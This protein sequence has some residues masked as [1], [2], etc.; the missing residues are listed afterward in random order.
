MLKII[1]QEWSCTMYGELSLEWPRNHRVLGTG[2]A[3]AFHRPS[4]NKFLNL[5]TILDKEE[6][7][8]GGLT[9]LEFDD[10]NTAGC[11]SLPSSRTLRKDI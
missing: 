7:R 9:R 5:F 6:M 11:T 4:M 2:Q 3:P 8:R 1:T 10:S